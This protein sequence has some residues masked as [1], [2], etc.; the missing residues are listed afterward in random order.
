[1]KDLGIGALIRIITYLVTIAYS[2]K[3]VKCLA[4]EK[5]IRKGKANEVKILL[6]FIAISLG[7]LVG[8]FLINLMYYSMLLKWLF[9]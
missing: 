2:F 5:F 1:M 9:I 4:L 7:Y 6:I 3:V 8:Q